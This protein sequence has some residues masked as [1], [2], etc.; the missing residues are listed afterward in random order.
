MPEICALTSSEVKHQHPSHA[1][2]SPSSR[3]FFTVLIL[4]PLLLNILC[5]TTLGCLRGLGASWPPLLTT[6]SGRN[7]SSRTVSP[8]LA[9][10]FTCCCTH[11]DC[12]SGTVSLLC[13]SLV[14]S[15][16]QALSFQFELPRHRGKAKQMMFAFLHLFIAS[17]EQNLDEAYDLEA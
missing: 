9:C 17:Q 15:C 6:S 10:W 7:L 11:R 8:L 12:N 16:R 3:G 13:Q 14:C 1:H 2:Q 5:S 4:Q